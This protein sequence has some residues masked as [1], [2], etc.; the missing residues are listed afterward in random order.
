[1]R[2][3][4]GQGRRECS[5]KHVGARRQLDFQQ[6]LMLALHLLVATSVLPHLPAHVL[7]TSG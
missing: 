4:T 1:M 3:V 5:P 7:Y 2:S 6:P